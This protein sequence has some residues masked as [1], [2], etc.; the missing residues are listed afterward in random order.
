VKPALEP[1]R[2]LIFR[3]GS[4]GDTV[5]ALPCFHL[6]ARLFPNADRRVLTNLP[7]ISVQVAVESVLNGSGLIHGYFGVDYRQSQRNVFV[8]WSLWK[9]IRQ[10]KPDLLIHLT[11]LRNLRQLAAEYAFFKFCGVRRI[12]GMPLKNELRGHECISEQSGFEHEAMRLARCLSTLGDARVGDPA[13]WDLRLCD[14]ERR[15]ARAALA[16]LG[17]GS[18]LIVCSA[19]TAV[20][21]KDWGVANWL[22]FIGRLAE[23]APGY[24][25]ALVG[26]PNE[27]ERSELMRSQWPGH[28]VNLC[29]VLNVR[30]SAAAIELASVYIGH[31]SGPMHLAAAVGVPCVAIFSARQLPGVWFPFGLGHQVIYHNVPCRNC[32]LDKCERYQKRCITS[33][34][35]EEVLQAAGKLLDSRRK[36]SEVPPVQASMAQRT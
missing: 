24:G 26:A 28:S 10:W 14:E 31:D 22:S 16:P 30:E 17:A 6:L 9:Q 5:V 4:L 20:E 25:L 33:I 8:Q 32:N 18:A 35:V 29:G 3:P 13:S 7:R 15:R 27:F 23:Q 34:T 19:G 11:D 1:K 12:V 21:L 2:I 36:S